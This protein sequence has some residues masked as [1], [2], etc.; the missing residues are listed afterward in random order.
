MPK[1]LLLCFCRRPVLH[2]AAYGGF[3][4]C[5]AHLLESG[6]DVDARDN[7]GVTAL[8]WA[9]AS[10][11]LD[12]VKLLV[13]HNAFLNY[14]ETEGDKLAP[15][16]YAISGEHQDVAQVCLISNVSSICL[17]VVDFLKIIEINM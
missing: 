9:C 10:G 2:Y 7:T 5:M 13:Q 4:S 1:V 14:V 17:P 11:S 3:Y 16:D 12:A 8:H 6:A 15:L